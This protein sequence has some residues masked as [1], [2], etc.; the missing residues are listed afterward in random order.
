MTEHIPDERVRGAR[1]ALAVL[2]GALGTIL[3]GAG[4]WMAFR[5]QPEPPKQTTIEPAEP[6]EVDTFTA[7]V[8]TETIATGGS[9]MEATPTPG[10]TQQTTTEGSGGTP[11]TA[12]VG[13]VAFRLGA[14][15]YVANEDGSE[16]TRVVRSADGPYALS[17]DGNTIAL[18]DGTSLQLIDTATGDEV[19]VGEAEEGM[20]PDWS[21]D[22]RS[23]VYRRHKKGSDGFEIRQ[24]ARDGEGARMISD[25]E[26]AAF[27]AK[28]RVLVV[29]NPEGPPSGHVLVSQDDGP[30]APIVVTGGT[31][32]A[33][34]SDGTRVFVGLSNGD[35]GSEVVSLKLDG[36]KQKSVSGPVPGQ[37]P[38][39]WSD[40]SVSPDSGLVAVQAR[41]DDG[42]S[43]VFIVPSS[44]GGLV[45]VTQRRDA[46][47]HA[48]SATGERLF[49]I[50]GN[51]FQGES[52][53]LVS[54]KR[55]G[56]ARRDVV[57]GAE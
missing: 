6:S 21:A 51:A 1:I 15:V 55:D 27:S 34:G 40:I 3:F 28:G 30:L 24:V 46:G 33:V 36:A 39:L 48:W 12:R 4:L 47:L 17:P 43:R 19:A 49:L 57:T 7:G 53:S 29:L 37:M 41:G 42:Y 20:A 50:E 5:P 16:A 35:R 32:T 8:A 44:G 9:L 38:A 22:S 52:T 25:G 14:S 45:S 13:K 54:V 23:V 10:A 26:K 56:S 11:Q 18:I 2:A 31:P